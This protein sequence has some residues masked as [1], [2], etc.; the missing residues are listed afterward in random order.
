MSFYKQIA[1]I[2]LF[3]TIQI[4]FFI[5]NYNNLFIVTLKGL[6]SGGLV[7][8]LI[9]YAFPS[10][11]KGLKNKNNIDANRISQ[12]EKDFK[13]IDNKY[14]N[15]L[16][17]VQDGISSANDNYTIGIYIIDQ[18]SG[19]YVLKSSSDSLFVTPVN[20][21]NNLLSKITSENKSKIYNKNEYNDNSWHELI[22]KKNWKGS[23]SLL[24]FPI[25][26]E[27][28]VIGALILYIDHFSKINSQDQPIVESL[29]NIFNQGIIDIEE[30]EQKLLIHANSNK[31]TDL[32]RDF[33]P[34]S[35]LDTFLN[36][37][38][39]ICRSI[40]KYDK[41][42]IALTSEDKEKLKVIMTDGFD[43]DIN[44]ELSFNAKNSILGLSFINNQLIH[45][46]DWRK[47]FPMMIRFDN[48]RNDYEE[49]STILS[50]PLRSEGKSIGNIS[51][52]RININAFSAQEIELI[53]MLC[54]NISKI[55]GWIDIHNQLNRSASRDGLTGLLNHKTF[56]SRFEKEINRSR[57]FDHH[58]GLIFFD[59]DK[60]KSVNDT[61]GHLYGDYVLEEVSRIISKN[62]RSIDILGRYGGEEF[63][64]LLVNTDINDCIPLAEK[65]VEKI[66]KK[67]YLK[68]GIAVN[69]TI[70]AGMS[71]FPIHSDNV[72]V[73]IA[74]ADKAMYRTKISG[75]NGVSIAE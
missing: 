41:L 16:K 43:E 55:L 34:E 10:V 8:I 11:F 68:D 71:G 61:Y 66:A 19:D 73:L 17:Q 25:Q 42:T 70:S 56:I 62:V 60:F 49:F 50:S 18:V 13:S 15:L 40:F 26:Y 51:F 6:A 48:D 46:A 54:E 14:K 44:D 36:S 67:T 33:N 12:K 21:Q 7:V 32:F 3:F 35:D 37:I 57:R 65:I 9:S 72:E 4:L 64:L 52:E 59:I 31:I 20:V 63:S 38:K 27:N 2:V 69:L 1:V 45:H 29:V 23:E 30:S 47:Q 74:K 39:T 28:N 58:L 53:A 22:D 24:G 5:P 75:G